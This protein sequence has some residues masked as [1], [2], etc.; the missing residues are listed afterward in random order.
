MLKRVFLFHLQRP[1]RKPLEQFYTE[2]D[3]ELV[4]GAVT[5]KIEFCLNLL[6][7]FVGFKFTILQSL[8]Y[9]DFFLFFCCWFNDEST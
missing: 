3:D 6:A 9:W 8:A 7:D 2:D 4:E 1:K 5:V